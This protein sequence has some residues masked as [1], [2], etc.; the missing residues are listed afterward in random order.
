[1]TEYMILVL[2]MAAGIVALNWVL[3]GIS[4]IWMR[5][6]DEVRGIGWLVYYLI[7]SLAG[8]IPLVYVIYHLIKR[9]IL[10]YH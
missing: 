6:P 10:K 2:V 8:W 9:N 1:M 5:E 7:V 4:R 3:Y